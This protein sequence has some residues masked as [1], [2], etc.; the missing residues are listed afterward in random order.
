MVSSD[1]SYPSPTPFPV[2]HRRLHRRRGGPAARPAARRRRR[3][4]PRVVVSFVAGARDTLA[5]E[6]CHA[7]YAL[8][9]G[10][11]RAAVDA[12]WDEWREKMSR[13]SKEQWEKQT[14]EQKAER[15]RKRKET[16]STDEHKA[17]RSK[18]FRDLRASERRAELERAR[19]IAVPFEKSKKRRA[20]MRAASVDFSGI[21]G[22]AVL[23]MI[24]EDGK[25][26]MRVQ[27]SGNISKA[28]I[29]GPV[30]DPAP[31]DAFD[32]D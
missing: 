16:V 31:P 23:Y 11:Y 1:W 2:H 6:L 9:D 5:H 32:S 4:A 28:N 27:T 26:I 25:T 3:G 17:K 18:L 29:V 21:R 7:C 20:E 8:D 19:P 12:A 15:E 22:N 13:S 30:V 10:G 24:S 14:D